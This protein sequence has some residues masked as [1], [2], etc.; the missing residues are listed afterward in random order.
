MVEKSLFCLWIGSWLHF[1]STVS[2]ICPPIWT[3]FS[4]RMLSIFVHLSDLPFF[5]YKRKGL[6]YIMSESPSKAILLWIC[7][8]LIS[9]FWILSH[10]LASMR[11]RLCSTLWHW[12]TWT[13]QMEHTQMY[14]IWVHLHHI[15]V[16]LHWN[17]IYITLLQALKCILYILWSIVIEVLTM[18]NALIYT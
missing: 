4:Y 5:I 11:I 16:H 18:C 10:G 13:Q 14:H 17:Y 9:N 1:I 2:H 8:S 15:T 6:K 12:K 3:K 7:E